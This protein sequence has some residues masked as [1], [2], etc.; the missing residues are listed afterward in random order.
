MVLDAVALG[1]ACL[2]NASVAVRLGHQ[3]NNTDQGLPA[4]CMVET[5]CGPVTP[6]AFWA[7]V[8]ALIVWW[9]GG[10]LHKLYNKLSTHFLLSKISHKMM[11]KN[12]KAK[13]VFS[14]VA[15]G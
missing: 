8:A 2:V 12:H 3:A 11:I 6:A 4:E 14:K 9:G 13:G 5:C 7:L 1:K 15:R 10:A